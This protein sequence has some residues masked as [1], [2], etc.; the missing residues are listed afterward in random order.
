MPE[1]GPLWSDTNYP[2]PAGYDHDGLGSLGAPPLGRSDEPGT[3]TTDPC[4]SPAVTAGRRA[5][6]KADAD[7]HPVL[8][9]RLTA[10]QVFTFAPNATSVIL[11]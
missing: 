2:G 3:Y 8:R 6:S 7:A 1:Q 5:M 10:F 11:T 9:G 4:K